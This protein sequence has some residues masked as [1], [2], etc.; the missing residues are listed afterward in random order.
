MKAQLK[1]CENFL[2]YF[3]QKI[4]S[5]RANILSSSLDPADPQ[6]P[7]SSHLQHFAPVSSSEISQV[8]S[9]MKPTH[10][11]S[12]V[13]PSQLFRDIFAIIC[14]FIL[15]IVN[16]SLAT[17]VVPSTFKNATL[18]PLLKKSSLD[19][20]DL[21]NDRPI[22]KLPF[23]SKIL[24]KVVFQQ[25]TAYLNNFNL[26]DKFQS[27]FRAIHSTESALLKVYNDILL[28]TDSGSCAILVLLDL[29][30][31]FDTIDHDILLQRLEHR[32]GL[33]GTVLTWSTSY[34]TD[35][36]FSVKLGPYSSSSATM[37][38]G[39]P[40]G[41]IL[42][43]LLFSLYMLPL[44]ASFD[45]YG[46]QYHCYADDTQIYLPVAPQNTCTLNKLYSCLNDIKSWMACNFLQLKD[47][48]S[49]V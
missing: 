48:K 18:Q 36:T 1:P 38:F 16:S 15:A 39:V 13:I 6:P 7:T 2:I 12:D 30:A 45:K 49:V 29:S 26:L 20:S 32:V 17:G 22:S 24:E 8:V 3:I 21:K 27:G 23:I 35:R 34:L 9:W 25:L 28:C 11:P 37:K 44:S 43:P 31:A 40:Q 42:G 41:S 47:R 5:I 33:E 46:I 19:S 10:C 14:P 4:D